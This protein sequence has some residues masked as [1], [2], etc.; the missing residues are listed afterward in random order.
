VCIEQNDC[1][2]MTAYIGTSIYIW[3]LNV[4]KMFLVL[5]SVWK[6]PT[7]LKKL[8]EFSIL[9]SFVTNKLL[10]P[11]SQILMGLAYPALSRWTLPQVCWS[12]ISAWISQSDCINCNTPKSTRVNLC[13]L[14]TQWFLSFEFLSWTLFSSLGNPFA[15]QAP[16]G[17]KILKELLSSSWTCG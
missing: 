9:L 1:L 12:P 8:E 4:L 17:Y 7:L 2:N 3:K 16:I 11:P 14:T 15:F 6:W 13:L 5:C 10:Y